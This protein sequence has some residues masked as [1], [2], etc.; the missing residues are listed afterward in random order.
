MAEQNCQKQLIYGK[1]G[2][3]GPLGSFI[4]DIWSIL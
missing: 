2:I 3:Q 4:M 1:L